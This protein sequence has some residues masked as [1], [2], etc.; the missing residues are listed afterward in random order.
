MEQLV[1]I[2]ASYQEPSGETLVV[3]IQKLRDLVSEFRQRNLKTP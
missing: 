1:G 3:P 2:V